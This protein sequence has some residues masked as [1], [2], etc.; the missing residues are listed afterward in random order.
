MTPKQKRFVELYDG[1]ATQ[2]A[3]QAGY[4]AGS[5]SVTGLQLLRNPKI[6]A[7][8]KARQDSE[9]RARIA[10]R[11]ERQEFLTAMMQ[12]ESVRNCDRLRAVELLC[13]SEGDFIERRQ[14]DVTATVNIFDA[15]TRARL[16]KFAAEERDGT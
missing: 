11:Q 8:I 5:A 15:K 2:A 9:S 14:V 10:T 1:N 3:V 16:L 6:A 7:A 4:A 13:K 12:D